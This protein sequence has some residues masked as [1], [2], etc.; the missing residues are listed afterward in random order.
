MWVFVLF[1]LSRQSGW[2]RL[3]E[4]FS[5]NKDR[6]P[7]DGIKYKLSS[8]KMNNASFSNCILIG[9]N[10]HGVGMKIM[11]LFSLFH[12]PLFIPW[13][14]IKSI[15]LED[16]SDKT[17]IF[18]SLRNVYKGQYYRIELRD[19]PEA[20]IRIWKRSLENSTVPQYCTVMAN[21]LQQVV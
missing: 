17:S 19:H 6:D 2:A 8:G 3:A 16:N 21:G 4:D 20:H 11:F 12:K 5:Q 18:S 13:S 7:I 14:N 10:E 1:A 15:T 9:A